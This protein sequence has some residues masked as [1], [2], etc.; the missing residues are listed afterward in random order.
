M[1]SASNPNILDAQQHG[2]LAAGC[3]SSIGI[4]I[5]EKSDLDKASSARSGEGSP[6]NQ[7]SMEEDEDEID[8]YTAGQIGDKARLIH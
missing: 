8:V 1:R 3:S 7:S 4:G 5:S 6:P 2:R